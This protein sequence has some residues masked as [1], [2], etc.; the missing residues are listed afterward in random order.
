MSRPCDIYV[1]NLAKFVTKGF[2]SRPV[3]RYDSGPD[4]HDVHSGQD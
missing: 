1:K 4:I 3:W 2:I